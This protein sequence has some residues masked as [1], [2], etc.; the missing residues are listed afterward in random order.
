[1]DNVKD[2]TVEILISIRDEIRELREDTN[3]RFEQMDRRFEQMDRRFE[4][5]EKQLQHIKTDI[6][7]IVS[8]FNRDYMLLANKVDELERTFHAHIGSHN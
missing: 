2:I 1:M 8:Y 7:A 3:K 5:M 6:K 4:Q